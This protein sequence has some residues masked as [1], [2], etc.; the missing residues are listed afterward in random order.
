MANPR[1]LPPSMRPPKRYVVFE[2][3]SESPIMYN[4]LVSTIWAG[5]M[6]LLGEIGAAESG[7]WF[8][9]NIYDDKRQIGVVKCRHDMVEKVRA[10]LSMVSVVS[11]SKC[12]VKV[13]G[14]TGT[15]KSA[16][17]KYLENAV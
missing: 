6:E 5:A 1:I 17:A 11:E 9:H 16:N 8:V 4:E 13:L 2:V 7:I 15:I 14:V 10:V 12:V 3:V